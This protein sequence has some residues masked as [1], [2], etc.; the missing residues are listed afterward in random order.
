MSKTYDLTRPLTAEELTEISA[1]VAKGLS[2]K[3]QV[4]FVDFSSTR[5]DPKANCQVENLRQFLLD[6]A[7]PGI[8]VRKGGGVVEEDVSSIVESLRQGTV[9]Y[10]G[11][12]R[13]AVV[14]VPRFLG[15]GPIEDILSVHAGMPKEA[16]SIPGNR[17]A[18]EIENLILLSDIRFAVNHVKQAEKYKK[19]EKASVSPLIP[20]GSA[21]DI[22]MYEDLRWVC[23]ELRASIKDSGVL[24][25]GVWI[26]DAFMR[27][28]W[29][30]KVFGFLVGKTR[31]EV[32]SDLTSRIDK[33]IG[34]G[35][36]N[37]LTVL[38]SLATVQDE[39]MNQWQP[40]FSKAKFTACF[41]MH[42]LP[43]KV[44]KAD[45]KLVRSFQDKEDE[46]LSYTKL[47]IVTAALDSFQRL[48]GPNFATIMPGRGP[49][50][51][52]RRRVGLDLV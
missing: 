9:S 6:N 10:L 45:E 49:I 26:I 24:Y 43:E 31:G 27:G 41:H 38:W 20:F 39:L 2:E 13:Q 50:N 16:M 22:Q 14:F 29:H 40:G 37:F 18:A 21:M 4:V 52:M 30:P 3:I 23:T 7:P 46:I 32:A 35:P 8:F 15:T 12:E 19:M 5:A 1:P 36:K 25:R 17:S 51:Q 47:A 28:G 34:D 44:T 48:L 11:D 33:I 42:F